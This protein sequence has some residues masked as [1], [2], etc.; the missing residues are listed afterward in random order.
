LDLWLTVDDGDNAALPIGAAQLLLPSYRLRFYRSTPEPLRLM[1][2][3]PALAAPRY[4]LALL[5]PEVMGAE[6]REVSPL[7]E[8]GSA[9]S[10]PLVSTR[11]FW[12]FLCGAVLILLLLIGRLA[13]RG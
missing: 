8:E 10:T 9:E 1:Y 13:R 3:A 5:A 6:A 2:G 11:S 12:I 4:D 7:E